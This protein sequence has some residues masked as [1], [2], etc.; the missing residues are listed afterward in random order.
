MLVYT[1]ESI[2]TIKTMSTHTI[3]LY[4][5]SENAA[6]K[7]T[8]SFI[9]GNNLN[10]NTSMWMGININVCMI[11]IY[12]STILQ[13]LFFILFFLQLTQ[14]EISVLLDFLRIK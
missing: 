7:V 1:Q 4:F 11:N 9:M 10:N 13:K 12:Q 14:V 8:D 2:V 3:T 5:Q 6:T